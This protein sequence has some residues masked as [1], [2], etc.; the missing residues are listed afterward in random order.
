MAFRAFEGPDFRFDSITVEGGPLA[1]QLEQWSA[2]AI[3]SGRVPCVYLT[4]G[5]CPPSVKLEKSLTDPLLQRALRGVD[6]A[7]LD[8]DAWGDQLVEAGFP[9]RTVPV[10]FA[11]DERGHA[12]GPNITGGAWGENTPENMAPPIERFFDDLRATRPGAA[13]MVAPMMEKMEKMERSERSAMTVLPATPS[14]VRSV[15]M[16][17]GALLLLLL[18]A[19]LKVWFA[20]KQQHEQDGTER[21]ERIRQEA[22]KAIQER[23]GNTNK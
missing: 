5:W 12:I 20:D 17:I 4:A 15:V 10:F 13:A 21:D 23:L 7:T 3:A 22:R 8:I 2:R 16:V 18:A 19:G 6:A 9:A 11:V 14:R 1:A